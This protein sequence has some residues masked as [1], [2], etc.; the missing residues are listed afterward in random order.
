MAATFQDSVDK[1]RLGTLSNLHDAWLWD[2]IERQRI[3][4]AGVAMGSS[5]NPE[6]YARPM[7]GTVSTTTIHNS[8]QATMPP[9]TTPDNGSGNGKG[10]GSDNGNGKGSGTGRGGLP[11][12]FRL[13]LC[14]HI[15]AGLFLAA[16]IFAIGFVGGMW[17]ECCQG[18]RPKPKPRPT[19]AP[20]VSNGDCEFEVTVHFD[21]QGTISEGSKSR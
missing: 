18:S 5:L 7:P 20:I 10:S 1:I 3:M 2:Q 11:G 19:P 21:E 9:N 4:R 8:P 17:F 16:I 13:P 14:A 15:F 6:E 12:R